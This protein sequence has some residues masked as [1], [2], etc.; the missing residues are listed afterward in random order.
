MLLTLLHMAALLLLTATTVEFGLAQVPKRGPGPKAGAKQGAKMARR[1]AELDRF[2]RMSPE[3][4]QKALDRLPA[5]RRQRVEQGLER[6]RAMNPENRERLRNFERM[7]EQ[8]REAV[9]QNFRRMQE[10]PENR[11][12]LV[13]RE[14]QQLRRMSDEERNARMQSEGF[15][16]RFDANEQGLIRDTVANLPPDQE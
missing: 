9:R 7:P 3:Q 11:R 12:P 2:E 13:R 14:L 1:A 8:R 5:E 6:Y 4:R 15:R 10:L 16:K